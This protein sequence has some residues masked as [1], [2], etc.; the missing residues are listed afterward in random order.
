MANSYEHGNEPSS[1]I[2]T[3]LHLPA[4]YKLLNEA[5]CVEVH[6]FYVYGVK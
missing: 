4:E 6:L 1:S 2:Q 3:R 5:L